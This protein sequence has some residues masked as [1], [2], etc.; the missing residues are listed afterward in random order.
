MEL[1]HRIN[2]KAIDDK[3]RSDKTLIKV[4]R[5]TVAWI[6]DDLWFL[7]ESSFEQTDLI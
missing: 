3:I 5:K 4:K 1:V 7:I 2:E 6:R